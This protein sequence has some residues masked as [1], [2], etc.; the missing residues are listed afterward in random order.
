MKTSTLLI[1]ATL[2]VAVLAPVVAQEAPPSSPPGAPP[3][4][5][6]TTG[7]GP[8][9]GVGTP[10]P[11]PFPGR[12]RPG[13]PQIGDPQRSPFPEMTRPIFLS[14]KVIMEDGSPPPEPVTIERVCNGIARPEQ[15]TDSRG[16]FSFQ[17]GQNS[18]MLP[19]ASVSSQAD[20]FGSPDFSNRSRSNVPGGIGGRQISERDLMGCEL[21]A[22]LPGYRSE[23][24]QL[25]GRR[26]MDNPD[27]GTIILRRLGN[28]EGLT[29]SATSLN[30]PK[31]A[32]KALDK[33]KDLLKKKKFDEAQKELEKAVGLYP[34]YALAWHHLGL[35]HEQKNLVEE[36]RKAYAKALEADDKYVN[37]YIQLAQMSFKE[38]KWQDVSDTTDRILK[39]N[40]VDFPNAF[41]MNSIANLY[42]QKLDAAE[43]S[44]R[45]AIKI[46]TQHRIPKAEHL[47]GVILAQ[48]HDYT[49][50]AQHM[51]N[52]LN[53]TP[54]AAD[55]DMVKKQLV[56]IDRVLGKTNT[57]SQPPPQQ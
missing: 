5:G 41:F 8:G 55:A 37:P 31:D 46:D 53:L 51:R 29:I 2:L 25:S 36:A 39:L 30:A 7:P 28:V 44:A 16:R 48:K 14:G 3:G 21:R 35:V 9:P 20:D 49:G 50:A 11:S 4:G 19:D 13:Q 32:R 54:L 56:E 1:L 23:V 10:G 18:A 52:Y 34:R 57:A 38:Q 22:S 27:V 6:T 24:V 45:E 26:V 15:Y 17:L 42:L 40:P 33:S 43:R 47:L 12:D